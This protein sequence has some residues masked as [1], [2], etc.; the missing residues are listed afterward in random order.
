M[1]LIISV[2][3]IWFHWLSVHI[4]KVFDSS[5]WINAFFFAMIPSQI[6]K[7]AMMDDSFKFF[8]C[9]TF[10]PGSMNDLSIGWTSMSG[11]PIL[12]SYILHMPDIHKHHRKKLWYIHIEYLDVSTYTLLVAEDLLGLQLQ[13]QN[14]QTILCCILPRILPE[15]IF[16]WDFQISI[17]DLRFSF[18]FPSHGQLYQHSE[19]PWPTGIPNH[20]LFQPTVLRS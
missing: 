19:A 7:R 14:N 8:I 17:S 13:R 1:K 9:R 2:L 3:W 10:V 4:E 6:K 11:D 5:S 20:A 18:C 16:L 15:Y 12:Y